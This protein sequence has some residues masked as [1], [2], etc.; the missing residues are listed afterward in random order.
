M[1][2]SWVE[3][4][5]MALVKCGAATIVSLTD[6]TREAEIVNLRLFP[7]RDF[8]LRL[9]PWK[10][11][12]I[13]VV[14]SPLSAG[15]VFGYDY[16]FQLPGDCLRLLEIISDSD[17]KLENG[18]IATMDS[19]INIRYIQRI[20]N[21]T[22]LD[23]MLSDLIA[24]YLAKE[25]IYSLTQDAAMTKILKDDFQTELRMAKNIDSKSQ[26]K[27]RIEMGW[28]TDLRLGGAAGSYAPNGYPLAPG[29][30]PTS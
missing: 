25:I 9:H 7:C 20:D 19:S 11:A 14:L 4:A 10:D 6:L 22:Q 21:P 18:K 28:L 12:T 29:A 1:A 26:T 8:V 17:Y 5:N 30:P 24:A 13:R 23:S 27:E 15:P 3:I 16:Y 2:A